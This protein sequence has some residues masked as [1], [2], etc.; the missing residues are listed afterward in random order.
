[1]RLARHILFFA[2]TGLTLAA[3]TA[4]GALTWASDN[5][6]GEAQP[7]QKIVEVAFAF[8]NTGEKPVA[9]RDVQTNCDCL[10]AS[11]DRKIYQPGEAGV[12]TARF[13]VGDRIG[14][15]ERGIAVATDDGTPPHRLRVRIE[16]PEVA[17]V[18]PRVCEWRVGSAAEEQSADVTVAAGIRI[19]FSEVFSSA[20]SFRARFETL[21]PGRHYRMYFRPTN[22]AEPASAGIRLK[23]K[24]ATGEDVIVSAYANVH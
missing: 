6:N 3:A 17:A 15:Y 13:T 8:K 7:L 9:I 21:E 4:H 10:A 20:D 24:A 23:G 16:V 1:M 18:T 5:F 22:T 2:L 12:V 14:T 19:D 11:A